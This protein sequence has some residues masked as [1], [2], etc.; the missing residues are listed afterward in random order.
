MKFCPECGTKAEGFKFCPECG[1]K[2]TG[3]AE[4]TASAPKTDDIFGGGTLG[5]DTFGKNDIF[6]DSG[7]DDFDWGGAAQARTR[8]VEAQQEADALAAFEWTKHQNGKYAIL[9]LKDKM[10]MDVTVPAGVE[11][12]E[13]GAFEGSEV[14]RVELPEGL[15]KIGNRAFANCRELTDIV[16]PKSLKVIGNEAFAGCVNLDVAAPERARVGN[17]AFKDTLPDVRRRKAEEEAERKRKAAEEAERRRKAVEE[18]ERRRREAEE[19]ERKRKAAEEAERRRREV[20][21]AEHRRKAA[22]EAERKRKAAEEAERKRKAELEEQREEWYE[23]G[24][25]YY[26]NENYAEAVK[27]Y[28]KAAEQG[29][30]EAQYW[31]GVCYRWGWGI[32][33]DKVEAVKWDRKAAEQGYDKAQYTLGDCYYNGWGVYENKAEAAK[34]YHKAAEQGYM[35]AQTQLGHCYYYGIGV[36]KDYGETVKWYRRAAAQGSSWAK[37]WLERNG[38]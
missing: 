1:Y 38:Y 22:E 10:E 6:G 29:H 5:G 12:I 14:F 24:N 2:L 27:W 7:I 34:W 9:S 21:E 26:G 31:L 4:S 25:R 37:D 28:R 16:F 15:V 36:N 13:N 35:D 11:A 8:D 23:A 20:E 33:E 3:G 30:A 19:A 17:D 18:A 32:D